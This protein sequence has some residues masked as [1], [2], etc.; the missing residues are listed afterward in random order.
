MLQKWERSQKKK[1]IYRETREKK[2]LK[3]T[4]NPAFEYSLM[5]DWTLLRAL[6]AAQQWEFF[7][8]FILLKK[9]YK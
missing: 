6:W 1:K 7:V 3:E 8:V 2:R 5:H 9:N 4:D